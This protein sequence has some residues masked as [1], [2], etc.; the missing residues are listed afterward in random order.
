MG[1]IQIRCCFNSILMNRNSLLP[2]VKVL[3]VAF[4]VKCI[5]GLQKSVRSSLAMCVN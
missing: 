5:N 1:I 3:V 4:I 2:A